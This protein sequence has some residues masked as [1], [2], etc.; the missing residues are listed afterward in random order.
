[1]HTDPV[2]ASRQRRVLGWLRRE[3]LPLLV[4]VLL[5]TAAR[6]SLANHYHVPSGSM[7]PAL[8]PGD[9]VVVDMRAYGWRLP[10]TTHDLVTV[11]DPAPGDVVVFDSP[12]D[13]T[14]LIKRVAAV[15]GQQVEVRGG[16]L[17]VE[18]QRPPE[19]ASA[20][21]HVGSRRITLD[22]AHGG[23]ADFGPVRV[24][25]GEV[26][27]LG[28]HRGASFDGRYFGLVPVDAFYGRAVA[29]YHRRGDGFGWRRL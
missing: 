8:Q 7:Q 28:D 17:L 25:E 4:L 27:V 5:L 19:H 20:A 26:L 21:E 10:F 16:R 2:I 9:R 29:V 6:S 12:A 14:R 23:G 1:M 22:L 24:P 15:G 3:A 13:G 18:G 11:A